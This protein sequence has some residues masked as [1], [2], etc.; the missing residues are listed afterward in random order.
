MI[1][2]K[3]IT[4]PYGHGITSYVDTVLKLA[5]GF[6][7]QFDIYFPTG[8]QGLLKVQLHE[9]KVQLY[10]FNPG[11][12]FFGDGINISFP[13]SHL[14]EQPPF[15]LVVRHYNEDEAY[16][17]SFQLRI[18]IVAT[19]IFIARFLPSVAAEAMA[20]IILGLKQSEE[21]ARLSSLNESIGG[22]TKLIEGTPENVVE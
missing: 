19:E 4:S 20:K 12:W 7:Y 1:F 3:T 5:S 14:I 2:S 10:P 9:Y 8:S 18:G 11:E 17:H 22:L 16:D 13:E 21:D 15:Q 6:I